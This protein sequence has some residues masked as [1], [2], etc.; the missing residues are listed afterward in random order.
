MTVSIRPKAQA[1]AA[2]LPPLLVDAFAL[3]DTVA[4]G[5]HGRKRAGVG[6][7]F[8]QFR[9]A[10]PGDGY[11]DIDWRRSALS[12]ENYV[13]Q[14]EWHISQTVQLWVD[15]AASMQ[16]ASHE[17]T[18]S[19]VARLIAMALCVLLSRGGE[20]FGTTGFGVPNG[21]GDVQ[22]DRMDDFLARTHEI[23]D[24]GAPDP[25]N[26]KAKVHAVLISDFLGPM[27]AIEKFFEAAAQRS[28]RGVI[29]KIN[30]PM[31]TTF[32][33]VGNTIFESMT[34]KLRHQTQQAGTLRDKYLLAF[35]QRDV[36]L[37]S[38]ANQAGWQV[39]TH[40]TSK[41]AQDVLLPLYQSIQG[42]S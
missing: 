28:V 29:L 24:F 35:Q 9:P 40:E 13:R 3:A 5:A 21:T 11:R 26:L 37:Q 2:P 22:L 36:L 23:E 27:N 18:K 15:P 31:E 38:M 41:A 25:S 4:W 42:Q 8:W 1:L 7:A 34:G 12:D 32:P 19:H 17:F 10:Q 30:D 16:F 14:T 6:D 39:L 20:R 33:F